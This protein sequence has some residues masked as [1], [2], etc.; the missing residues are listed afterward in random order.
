MEKA[1]MDE[2]IELGD[3]AL[4]VTRDPKVCLITEEGQE[5]ITTIKKKKHLKYEGCDEKQNKIKDEKP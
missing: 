2:F 1:K 5:E 3:T 4:N